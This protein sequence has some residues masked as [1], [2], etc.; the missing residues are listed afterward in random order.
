MKLRNNFVALI[1]THG[2]PDKVH[3][4]RSLQRCGYTGPYK[5][6]VDNEDKTVDEYRKNFG[7]ENVVVFDKE[8]ISKTFDEADNFKDRRSIVYARNASYEIA[9]KLGYDYFIQLDDDYTTFSYKF[10][11]QLNYRH[12]EIRSLDNVFEAMLRFYDKANCHVLA[13]AQGG[14]FIGGPQS[15]FSETIKLRRKAMNTLICSNKRKIQFVGRINEDVNAYTYLQQTG[16]IFFTVNQVVITQIQTQSN[17]GGMSDIYLAN[18]T[19]VKSFYTLIFAPSC[20]Q[21]TRMGMYNTR[22]H[23]RINWDAA[24]PKILSEKYKKESS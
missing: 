15:G 4:F 8:A 14:D 23:H 7:A 21:I 20:T 6:V 11:C 5:I 9:E 22:L 19:Y 13:F 1:L 2:R 24:A 16:K 3:T 17:A 18:G 12:K 10:D